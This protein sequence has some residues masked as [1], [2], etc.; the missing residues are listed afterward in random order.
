MFGRTVEEICQVGRAGLVDVSDP[1]LAAALD[2]R[3]R[4]GKFIGELT[5]QRRD[6]TRFPAEMSTTLFRNQDGALRTSM[7]V[8][9]ISE[10]KRA[11]EAL[12]E[13]EARY[14]HTLDA[15]LEGC[16]IIGLDWRYL[17]LNDVADLHNRRPKEELLG[18][19]YMEM[20]PGI[21]STRVFA[22][23]RQCMEERVSRSMENEFTFPDGSKGWFELRMYPVPEGIVILSIDI[24]VRK[25]ADE[26]LR[27][28]EAR[29]HLALDAAKAGAWE[30]DLRTN[31]NIWSEELWNL[32]GLE[33]HSS[34]PSYQV[35]QQTIHPDDRIRAEQAVQAAAR[36]GTE[37][38]AEWRVLDHGGTER[39][40]MSRGQ[41]MLDA[42]GQV[43]RFTGIVLDITERKHAEEQ[44]RSLSRAV[45]QSPAVVVIT[46]TAGHIEYVNPRF[47]QVTGYAIAE[48]LGRNPR[49][50]K[51]GYTSQEEYKRLWD[52]ITSGG[53]WRGEFWNKKKNGEHYWESAAISP[54]LNERGEITHFLAVKEDITERRRVQAALQKSEERYRGL[55]E[56]M[57]E[58]YAYCKMIYD[59]GQARDW[60][61]LAVNAAFETLTG[62]KDVTGKRVTEVIPG[63]RESDRDL[64]NIYARV[65]LTGKP[66]KFEMFVKALKMWFSISVYSPEKEFFVAVFDVITDR[67]RAEESLRQSE[68]RFSKA[69][70]ANPAAMVITNWADGRIIDVNESYERLVGQSRH[71][72]LGRT[73]PEGNTFFNPA[74]HQEIIRQMREQGSLPNYETT[75]RIKPGDTRHVLTS[76]ETIELEGQASLLSIFYDITDRKRAEEKLNQTMEDLKRSNAELEQFAYV[77]SHDLQEP[78]RMVASYTQLLARR[79]KGQLDSDADEFIAYAVDGA[80]RMQTLI[81]DLLAYSQVGTRGNSL[82]PTDCE[83]V[84]EQAVANLSV[85]IEEQGAAVTHDPLPTL[86]AD[87]SQLVQLFQNLLGNAIKFRSKETPRVHVSAEQKGAEWVFSVCDNGIGID[88]QYFKRIFVIFQRLHGREEYPGTGIGLA[89]CKKIVHRHGGRLWVESEPGQGSTFYFAIPIKEGKQL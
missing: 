18:R 5:C 60:E 32:Y 79:Y 28:S 85:A 40:L 51:S 3:A 39:W 24:T 71:E 89:I 64:F 80:V 77:A 69:F 21:E 34:E 41:P 38:N 13:S 35:W 73:G 8:R 36:D 82:E 86:I 19:K 25:R 20:W 6:G 67:K 37:L 52:T 84:F 9:D 65:A 14:R 50:L 68:E 61:Y 54:I 45:E 58:G 31:E 83:N 4:T 72:L 62:L 47:T 43:A 70:H 27:D 75:L 29:L 16:Q 59:N 23:I 66:E 49:I 30:W 53:E 46:D 78:L 88:P 56:H 11:E 15:M 63:I 74:E 33:P 48:V 81:N 57:V 17:Y 1:R 42:E 10:R 44:L 76:L 22:V 55:F 12:R 7:I 2:E 87:A 26:Q